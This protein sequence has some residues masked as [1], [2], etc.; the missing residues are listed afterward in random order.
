MFGYIGPEKG[1]LKVRELGEYQAYYCGLC[2]MIGK[3]FGQAAR[4]TLSYDCAFIALLVDAFSPC[5]GC[6]K[7]RCAYKPLKR[8]Q[9]MAKPSAGLSFA[10]D[11]NVLLSY[12]KLRDNWADEKSA[13]SAAGALALQ[14]AKER[15][16]RE[17]PK[18]CA[19]IQNGI[20]ALGEI[21]KENAASLDAPSEAFGVMVRECMQCAPL[22]K[23]QKAVAS[24]SYSIGKWIYLMDAWDDRAKDAKSGSYNPFLACGAD[25]ERAG[26]LLHCT[27]NEAIKAFD[28]LDFASH[29]GVLEN[30]IYEGCVKRTQTLLNCGGKHE[31]QPV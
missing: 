5:C 2:R 4:L 21:E 18:L 31:Q 9:M 14:A 1:E 30:I 26:F 27:L 22:D 3:R 12:Y 7:H 28:L 16:S 6:E 25:Q 23:E 24:L 20:A 19:A 17:N 13:V 29:K 15:A 11:M 8:E 10:S